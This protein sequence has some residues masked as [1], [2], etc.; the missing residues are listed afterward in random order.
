MSQFDVCTN[1]ASEIRLGVPGGLDGRDDL[2]TTARRRSLGRGQDNLRPHPGHFRLDRE[3]FVQA[4][5]SL[6]RSQL[7]VRPDQVS[8]LHAFF[9]GPTPTLPWHA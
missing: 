6:A 4:F 5:L 2:E 9:I 8:G 7:V 1:R 3:Q